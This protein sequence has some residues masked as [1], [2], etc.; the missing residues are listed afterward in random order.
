LEWHPD[1][2]K[3]DKEAAE[4]R[5]K[6]INEAYQ[7]LSDPQKKAAFDQ[8]G[9]AAFTPGGNA[10]GNPLPDLEDKADRLPT[11]IQLVGAVALLEMWTLAI[12][13][14]FLKVFLVGEIHLAADKDDS[15]FRAIQSI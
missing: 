4:K 8:Y 10:G 7:V 14:I 3:D 5:F 1:R 12:R 9:S 13:L 6:E 2:H 15:K 11:L